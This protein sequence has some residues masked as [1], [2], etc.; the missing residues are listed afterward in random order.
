MAIVTMTR[1]EI[2]RIMTPERRKRETEEMNRYPIAYDEDC[3][4]LTEE[5]LAHF[6]PRK[7]RPSV[8]V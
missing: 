5:R 2:D 1:E 7:E 3:P 6:T 8:A 4:P